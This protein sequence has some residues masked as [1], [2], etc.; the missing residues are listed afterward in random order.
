MAIILE[1]CDGAGKSTLAKK[2]ETWEGFEVV[3]SD[4]MDVWDEHQLISSKGPKTIFDRLAHLSDQVYGPVLRE[5][6]SSTIV[7]NRR[8]FD[9]ML[10]SLGGVVVLCE[11]CLET[12]C[13]GWQKNLDSK[14]PESW[15]AFAKIYFGYKQLKT[16]LPVITYDWEND[17]LVDLAAKVNKVTPTV[18][19]G[20]GSGSWNPGAV[21]LLVGDKCN[22]KE[23]R[24]IP[25]SSNNGSSTWLAS[26]LED[27]GFPE[28]R[29]YWANSTL[30]D[31]REIYP[32]YISDLDP[33]KIYGLGDT[34]S[35]YLHKHG[36]THETGPHPQH[37]KRFHYSE[38]YPLI[39]SLLET[40]H[41]T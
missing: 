28:T 35:K 19:K 34:A 7:K 21:V 6:F 37:W 4:K 5:E 38:P 18:N 10:L 23:Q 8:I 29:L 32:D 2:M 25:F 39:T 14:G 33:V 12:T 31:G 36:F 17:N 24:E 41:A 1:G 3:H 13:Q 26:E 11:P 30:W 20:P 27:V 9:R 22:L 15:D 40:W 16:D